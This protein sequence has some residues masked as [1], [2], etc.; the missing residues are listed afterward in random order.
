MS[1]YI[2]YACIV[3]SSVMTRNRMTRVTEV[4]YMP[5]VINGV[6]HE[7]DMNTMYGI[8]TCI[9]GHVDVNAK[10]YVKCPAS[11]CNWPFE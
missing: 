8:A 10:F 4:C 9:N 11:G 5:M 1:Q 7:H 2:P 3:C 6:T